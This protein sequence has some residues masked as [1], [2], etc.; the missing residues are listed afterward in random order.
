MT[1]EQT[2]SLL[3]TSY[4]LPL[5]PVVIFLFVLPPFRVWIQVCFMEILQYLPIPFFFLRCLLNVHSQDVYD[6]LDFVLVEGVLFGELNFK[7]DD[8]VSIGHRIFVEGQP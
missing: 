6:L 2:L 5:P 1:K 7:L 4:F 3:L 8:Q